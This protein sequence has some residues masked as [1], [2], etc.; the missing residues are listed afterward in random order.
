MRSRKT[1][2]AIRTLTIL[3][4]ILLPAAFYK[5]NGQD[6][7][8]NLNKPEREK[9]FTS[10]G[11]G[12]FIHWSHDV[13]LGMVISH[14]MVGASEEYLNRY[15][16]ELPKYFDPKSFNADKWARSAKMA[17][18]KYMVF[19]TKHHNGFCMYD[20]KTTDFNI[21]N[22]PFGKDA[23]KMV[24]DA[25]RK[26]GL[27]VGIYFSPDDFH[28]LYEQ[29]TLISRRRPE[30]LASGNA[31][32]NAYVKEQIRELMTNYGKVDIVF[33]DG[34][35]QF[36][37]TELAKV[38]WE[39]NPDVV[40]T[41]GAI[42]TPEQETPGSPIP[43]PWESCYTL[44]EQWQFRPTNEHYKTARQVIEMLIETRAK[45][46]NLLLNVGP[47]PEG[48]IPLEQAGILNEVSL[49]MFI[50]G[51]AFRNTVPLSTIRDDGIYFLQRPETKTTYAFL[52]EQSWQ[53]GERREFMLK[54]FKMNPGSSI[55][56][57]GHNGKVLEYSPEV[58]PSPRMENVPGGLRV[59]VMR[60]QRIYND[61]KWNNPI[62]IRLQNVEQGLNNEKNIQR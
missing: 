40:V 49:W 35:E 32:L 5:L 36:A 29:G 54:D 1:I 23:T 33:L 26:E 14:T 34:T 18:M 25:C 45:G 48:G 16:N 55:A 20:T 21:M 9:W 52:P 30:A 19:T 47:T 11:F 51:E 22:T 12:M 46:G 43:S 62:V 42:M 28:F 17:G 7:I 53:L 59:S 57:L 15:V 3:V 2:L 38:C 13:T 56:V 37:K 58:D 10:L 6:K 50:N 4:T 61:R 27:A 39:I 41:R 60:A 8:L 44:G 24:I 31:E